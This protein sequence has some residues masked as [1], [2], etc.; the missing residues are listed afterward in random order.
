MKC[1]ECN[2]QKRRPR[3]YGDSNPRHVVEWWSCL[4]EL[5][6]FAELPTDGLFAPDGS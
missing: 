6:S 5:P 3:A 1:L 4:W 2:S